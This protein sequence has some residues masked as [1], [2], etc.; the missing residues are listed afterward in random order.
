MDDEVVRLTLVGL[1]EGALQRR[2][3]R[4][5]VLVVALSGLGAILG[6]ATASGVAGAVWGAMLAIVAALAFTPGRDR[7][8]GVFVSN[9]RT[10]LAQDRWRHEPSTVELPSDAV[11]SAAIEAGADGFWV[12]TKVCRLRL[13]GRDG[14]VAGLDLTAIDPLAV[15]QILTEAGVPVSEEAASALLS[16]SSADHPRLWLPQALVVGVLFVFGGAFVLLT[17]PAWQDDGLSSGMGA[18]GIGTVL[19]LAGEGLRRA[20]FRRHG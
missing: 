4:L 10:V 18:L 17:I 1:P 11:T 6:A 13:A 9:R 20:L 12:S 7:P 3:Q 14:Q 5:L 16:G 15:R 2:M 19:V 8:V